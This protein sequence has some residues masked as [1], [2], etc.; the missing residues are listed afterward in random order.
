[1]LRSTYLPIWGCIL[2][3]TLFS[4]C[5]PSG[6][7]TQHTTDNT[8]T[9]EVLFTVLVD[10]A[11]I[12]EKPNETSPEIDRL[13][14]NEF[15]A[16]TGKESEEP[17][18]QKIND[19]VIS[20]NWL[21]VKTRQGKTGWIFSGHVS[22]E[23]NAQVQENTIADQF[24]DFLKNLDPKNPDATRSGIIHFKK[25]FPSDQRHSTDKVFRELRSFFY[26]SADQLNERLY[27]PPLK[28]D[29]AN[30][31]AGENLNTEAASFR[32]KILQNG[33]LIQESEGMPYISADPDYLL[34]NLKNYLSEPLKSYL[35]QQT[36]ES[37]QGFIEDAGL[38]IPLQTLSD[39]IIW[40]ETFLEKHPDFIFRKEIKENYSQELRVLLTG[41]DNTPAFD[42]ETKQYKDEFLETL[43]TILI[44]YPESKS[45]K[46]VSTFKT[47]LDQ[48]NRIGQTELQ[49]F[50]QSLS[51]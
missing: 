32:A 49:S 50:L 5:S 15:I 30:F 27:V 8:K 29:I 24:S 14:K 4:H 34:R 20:G 12:H 40:K 9:Q 6:D 35:S 39:R 44:R 28:E 16:W 41:I 38:V 47:L 3:L 26:A 31:S 1:M 37:K 17:S 2:L 46:K 21:E 23:P 48:D 7:D 22:N 18:K 45:S 25:L 51:Y 19:E 42:F 33:F 11:S 36:L 10:K 43:D 13:G